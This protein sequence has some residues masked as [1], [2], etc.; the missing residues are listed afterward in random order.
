MNTNRG[1][2]APQPL[3]PWH[4]FEETVAQWRRERRGCPGDDDLVAYFEGLGPR[5]QRLR[6]WWHVRRCALC[7]ADLATLHEAF[8]A[9]ATDTTASIPLVQG[10][11]GLPRLGWRPAWTPVLAGGLVLSLTLHAYQLLAPFQQVE[12]LPRARALRQAAERTLPVLIEQGLQYQRA[13]KPG[14]A[15]AAYREALNQVAFPLNQVAWL[16]YQEGQG[17]PQAQAAEGLPL[18]RLAVQ[19]RPDE[20]EYLD[21]LAVLLCAVG[22]HAEALGWMEKA[23]A[24]QAQPFREKLE[25]FRRG[26]CQ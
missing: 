2:E 11:L 8:A 13:G 22:E 1:E 23:A 17:S 10:R 7:R 18:A 3:L 16:L 21:T 26:A 9:G 14:E 25:R 20:A 15:M 5:L 12:D 6:V 4:A 19:L 24:L